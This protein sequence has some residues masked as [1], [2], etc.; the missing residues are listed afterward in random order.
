M[1][2]ELKRDENGNI[3]TDPGFKEILRLDEL[4]NTAGIPHALDKCWDGWRIAYPCGA[5]DGNCEIDFIQT[6]QSYGSE[7]GFLEMLDWNTDEVEGWI[8]AEQ[9]FEIIA[10]RAKNEKN[11]KDIQR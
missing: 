5:N 4:L 7:Q 6:G 9:A 3:I 11:R 1:G 2:K 10:E 8:S